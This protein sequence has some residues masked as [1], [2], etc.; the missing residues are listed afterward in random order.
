MKED[1]KPRLHFDPTV[2]L[3]DILV[4]LTMLTA[5]FFAYS[6][7]DKRVAVNEASAA[8]IA[9]QASSQQA[10][11]KTAINEVRADVKDVQRSINEISR[12][13]ASRKP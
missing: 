9:Q 12:A 13:L 6:N 10:E 4:A 11:Q 2:S 8:L 1:D 5:G 7:L 3:S